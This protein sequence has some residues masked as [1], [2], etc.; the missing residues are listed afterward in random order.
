MRGGPGRAGE[1]GHRGGSR[2]RAGGD[3]PGEGERPGQPGRQCRAGGSTW[4]AQRPA[5]PRHRQRVDRARD[6]PGSADLP[7]DDVA[8]P[9][10]F[11]GGTS[12]REHL[13]AATGVSPRACRRTFRGA[14]ASAGDVPGAGPEP[15]PRNNSAGTTRATVTAVTSEN[16]VLSTFYGE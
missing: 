11:A 14:G 7:V 8:A 5:R 3:Q 2:P 16:P 1:R 12:P 4:S 9:V 13:R 6:L 10:G 15:L